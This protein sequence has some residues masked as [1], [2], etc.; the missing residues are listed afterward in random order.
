[1]RS[2]PSTTTQLSIERRTHSEIKEDASDSS[3]AIYQYAAAQMAARKALSGLSTSLSGLSTSVMRELALSVSRN[4][5]I[6][7]DS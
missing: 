7:E 5:L 3:R 6:I 1:M 2:V 4:F